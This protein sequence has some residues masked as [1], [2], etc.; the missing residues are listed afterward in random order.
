MYECIYVCI[1]VYTYIYIY[2]YNCDNVYNYLLF[3]PFQTCVNLVNNAYNACYTG[4]FNAQNQCLGVMGALG[5]VYHH[6]RDILDKIN[7]EHW[8]P[9]H[10][11][12]KKRQVVFEGM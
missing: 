5:T 3:L 2:I 6:A 12:L 8:A 9:K 7:P 11:L 4:I 10:L 1:Y